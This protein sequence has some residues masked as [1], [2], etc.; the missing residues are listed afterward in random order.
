MNKLKD[1]FLARPKR[2][3]PSDIETIVEISIKPSQF[4]LIENQDNN[5]NN[6]PNCLSLSVSFIQTKIFF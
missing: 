4:V 3:A 6:N 2:S 5:N 1:I